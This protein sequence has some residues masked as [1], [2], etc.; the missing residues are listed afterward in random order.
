MTKPRISDL[1]D[2][3][4]SRRRKLTELEGHLLDLAGDCGLDRGVFLRDYL[5]N[6]SDRTWLDHRQR[7][8]DVGW[9]TFAARH[10]KEARAILSEIGGLIQDFGLPA[11]EVRRVVDMTL[12]GQQQ[13]DHALTRM[14]DANLRRVVS[15]ARRYMNRGVPLSD[16]VQEGNM[17]LMRAV[18]RFDHRRGFRFGTFA[19]WWIRQ[20]ITRAVDDQAR[21]V[22]VPVHLLEAIR[23][24]RRVAAHMQQFTGVDPTPD[25]LAANLSFSTKRL[26]RVL[27]ADAETVSLD[28]LH[29]HHDGCERLGDII[30]DERAV[31]P[32]DATAENEL[33]RTVRDALSALGPRQRQIIELRFGIG[34]GQD[35]TLEEVGQRFDVTRERI[36]QI[37]AKALKKLGHP[38]RSGILQDLLR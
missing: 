17:G 14:I 30:E 7:L 31:S 6:G 3:I 33:L 32:L 2:C 35:H 18:E 23:K 16:L 4:R 22:R 29:E 27:L 1:V 28:E 19:T 24:T 37:E 11:D 34:L 38:V 10:S 26:L 25:Q 21:T 15:I 9:K 20:S 12:A 13:V 8:P 36:R 5:N